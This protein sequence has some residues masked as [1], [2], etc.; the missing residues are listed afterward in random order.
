MELLLFKSINGKVFKNLEVIWAAINPEDGKYQVEELD[1]AQ[2]DRFSYHIDVPY[3]VNDEYFIKQYGEDNGSVAC[4][5]WR[6]LDSKGKDSCSPRRLDEAL[7]IIEL[8]GNID[9]VLHPSTN[10]GKLLKELKS[11]SVLTRLEKL[12]KNGRDKEKLTKFFEQDNNYFSCKD[13]ILK[14]DN[15]L[16]EFISD[17][18]LSELVFNNQQIR[19]HCLNNLSNVDKF[20]NVVDTIIK[21]DTNKEVCNELKNNINWY[22]YNIEKSINNEE[23]KK[24][25]AAL[26]AKIAELGLDYVEF[27]SNLPDEGYKPHQKDGGNLKAETALWN[28]IE[29]NKKN[30]L[31]SDRTLNVICKGIPNYRSKF[32]NHEEI[33]EYILQ[34]EIN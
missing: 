27:N 23:L 7:N 31:S 33:K 14:K 24:H 9:N 17:E 13:Y 25:E 29:K 6:D 19:E 32:K 10:P 34:T 4:R 18:R 21:A 20:F 1:P 30:L 2:I 11:G 28:Y 22:T 8:G 12:L 15:S 16:T 5:W 26:T 3:D